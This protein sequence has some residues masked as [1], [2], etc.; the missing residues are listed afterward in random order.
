M[1][2]GMVPGSPIV[3][4]TSRINPLVSA[5]RIGDRGGGKTKKT[6]EVYGKR[7]NATDA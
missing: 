5:R 2:F 6:G 3:L 7:N 1:A 4:H